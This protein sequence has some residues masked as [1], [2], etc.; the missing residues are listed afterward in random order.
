MSTTRTAEKE[1]PAI[2][3]RDIAHETTKRTHSF[4]FLVASCSLRSF[5]ALSSAG[6]NLNGRTTKRFSRHR[7]L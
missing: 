2:T 1:K 3:A 4:F 6:S 7:F 5:S